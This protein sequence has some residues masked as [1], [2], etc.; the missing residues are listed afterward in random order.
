M[1]KTI[2]ENAKDYVNEIKKTIKSNDKNRFKKLLGYSFR[3]SFKGC[4][5]LMKEFFDLVNKGCM[6]FGIGAK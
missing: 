5:E 4:P 6:K 3:Q 1:E 2:W